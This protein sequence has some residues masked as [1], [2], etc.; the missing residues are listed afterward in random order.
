MPWYIL[1]LVSAILISVSTIVEKKV[2][3]KEHATEFST[4]FAIFNA[5]LCV[6]FIFFADFS[7][8]T[9]GRVLVIYF[10]SLL[11]T[12][13]FLLNAKST[14]HMEVSASSPWMILAPAVASILAFIFLGEKLS[15]LQVFGMVFMIIGLYVLQSHRHSSVWDPLREIYS[16]KYIHFILFSLLLYSVCA[17]ID[18]TL[19]S[20]YEVN[21]MAYMF[22]VHIFVA[23][24]FFILSYWVY[25]GIKGISRG[26]KT[27]GWLILLISVI[28][29]VHRTSTII[30]ISTTVLGLVLPIKRLSALFTTVIGGELFSEKNLTRKIVAC[31]IML[32]GVIFIVQ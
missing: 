14:R 6:P 4:V 32:A 28:T 9:I 25:D 15:A 8:L 16:S 10:A 3:V 20:K 29:V 11:G 7:N 24:N 2:L 19:L 5:V 17:L 1:P 18:R 31:L 30:A 27:Y 22:L 13:S 12:L 21:F 23:L 26:I